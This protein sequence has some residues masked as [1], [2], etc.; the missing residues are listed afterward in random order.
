[1]NEYYQLSRLILENLVAVDTSNPPGGEQPAAEYLAEFLTSVGFS[2]T[3]QTVDAGR[4]NVIAQLQ[5]G[6]GAS[7]LY[8]GHLD[9]VPAGGNWS[10]PPF[11]LT[12]R[13]GKLYGRGSCDM[14]SGVAAMCAAAACLA[15]SRFS[16]TLRLV[17]VA[18]EERGNLGIQTYL[19]QYANSDYT[20]IGEPTNLHVAVAHRGICRDYITLHGRATHAALA[21]DPENNA[22]LMAA[23]TVLG[24][25]KLNQELKSCRHPVLPP[26]GIVVTQL[27]GFEGENIV[28]GQV[29]LLT[30]FRILPGTTLEKA[31]DILRRALQ[32]GGQKSFKLENHFFM[33]GGQLDACHPFVSACCR[34]AAEIF[35][36]EETPR[37]FDAS[38]EQCYLQKMPT[39]ICGPGDMKQAH[40]WMSSYRR[41]AL[42][43]RGI[44]YPLA[45]AILTG[46]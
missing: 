44:L 39:L 16:G 20:V 5:Q 26:P 22:V 25:E 37:A 14:K 30:D 24:L 32:R 35:G 46:D 21:S 4:A 13:D 34:I 45:E 38:C 8:N 1:M 23:E 19:R 36:R 15:K 33:P 6:S 11:R 17:F 18:N 3:L 29:K 10:V 27:E 2:C 28:P 43:C 31:Q 40:T 12:E 41:T 7:L 42:S 9:V